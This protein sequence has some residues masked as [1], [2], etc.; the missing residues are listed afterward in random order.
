[1]LLNLIKLFV[2]M[3]VHHDGK[4]TEFLAMIIEVTYSFG[5][6]SVVCEICHRTGEAYD[7]CSDMVDEFDWYLFPVRIQRIIPMIL[8][9]TQQPTEIKCFGSIACNREAF[10]YVSATKRAKF[11]IS[12]SIAV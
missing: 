5:I 7:E 12:K 8:Q 6:L 4:M 3:Q 2:S 10:K 9:F 1:M 11:C